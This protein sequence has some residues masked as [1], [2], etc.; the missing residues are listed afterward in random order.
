MLQ[1]K[2]VR[3]LAYG[4]DHPEGVTTGPDGL[5]YAGGL[6][7]Q[8]YR[9]GEDGKAEEIARTGGICLGLCLDGDGAIYVCDPVKK[10]VLRVLPNGV[11]DVW[12][13]RTTVD[14]LVLPN[15]CAFGPDGSLWFTDSGPEDPDQP[16]GRLLRIPP[17]GG[18]AEIQPL[19]PLH[20]PNGLCVDDHG[21]VYFLES[22]GRQLSSYSNGVA[23][24]IAKTPNHN[25]DGVALDRDGGFIIVSYYPFALLSLPSGSSNPT[26]LFEDEWG[27][28]LRMP[29]NISYFSD[30]LEELAISSLGGFAISGVTP[31]V[32]G[33][34]LHYP[35]GIDTSRSQE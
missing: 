13:D 26:V 35:R 21:I 17:G 27:I 6:G 4:L 19:E 18:P 15:D 32:P 20:F 14:E 3:Q 9:C 25:P 10:A 1:R 31:P 34:P 30:N 8:I 22:F 24:T 2:D 23:T 16:Q 11:V 7:G 12:C 33:A 5:L 29:A 28:T